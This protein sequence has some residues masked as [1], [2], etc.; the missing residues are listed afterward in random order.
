MNSKV[1]SNIYLYGHSIGAGLVFNFFLQ[2][3]KF[4]FEKYDGYFVM[5][6]ATHIK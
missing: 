3:F 5:I 2:P 4:S 1:S 6:I